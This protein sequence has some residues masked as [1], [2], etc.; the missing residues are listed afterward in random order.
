[1]TAL[2]LMGRRHR[3][4]IIAKLILERVKYRMKF[5]WESHNF[6]IVS[7][8]NVS[9]MRIVINVRFFGKVRYESN[10]WPRG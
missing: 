2:Y 8:K 1:M 5:V 9:N 4:P 10:G 3:L 7:I 6:S